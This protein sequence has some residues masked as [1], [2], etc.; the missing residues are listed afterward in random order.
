M[1]MS[2]D[3]SDYYYLLHTLALYSQVYWKHIKR[4][5]VRCDLRNRPEPCK[6]RAFVVQCF[7][8]SSGPMRALNLEDE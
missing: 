4:P 5:N 6:R 1:R 3:I 7:H 8:A 2:L